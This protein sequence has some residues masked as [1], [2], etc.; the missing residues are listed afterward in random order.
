MRMLKIVRWREF[1][2]ILLYQ[3]K[4]GTLVLFVLYVVRIVSG[5]DSVC[6][7]CFCLFK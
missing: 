3:V 7:Y 2:V 5:E 6:G 1:V 4:Q